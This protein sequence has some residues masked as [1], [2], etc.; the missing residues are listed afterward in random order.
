[1][2]TAIQYARNNWRKF[3]ACLAHPELPLDKNPV[4]QA[5]RPFTLGRKNWIFSGSPRGAEASA[6]M[7]SLVETAKANDWEPK[8]YLQTLFERYPL[9]KNDE[10]RRALLPQFLKPRK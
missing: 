6:F 9:A 7:Y 1:M 5:I 4:E 10:Q 2:H 3:T 8:A